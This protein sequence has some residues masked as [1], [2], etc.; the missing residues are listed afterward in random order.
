M[1]VVQRPTHTQGKTREAFFVAPE[2]KPLRPTIWAQM[3]EIES[4]NVFRGLY[5]FLA[6]PA[7]HTFTP[8][9]LYPGLLLIYSLANFFVVKIV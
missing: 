9:I 3:R 7:V 5:F 8:S 1:N 4:D 2:F 6:F